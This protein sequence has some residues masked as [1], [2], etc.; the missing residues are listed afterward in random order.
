MLNQSGP[1]PTFREINFSELRPGLHLEVEWQERWYSVRVHQIDLTK[2]ARLVYIDT[3]EEEWLSHQDA[4]S[5]G[6]RVAVANTANV[7]NGPSDRSRERLEQEGSD[8]IDRALCA[9]FFL[10]MDK[11]S[12][13][14]EVSVIPDLESALEKCL[15]ALVSDGMPLFSF[16]MSAKHHESALSLNQFIECVKAPF[17]GFTL[18]DS[19]WYDGASAASEL[20]A[21]LLSSGRTGTAGSQVQRAESQ[22]LLQARPM[23][24]CGE[25]AGC[26]GHALIVEGETT[27][28]THPILGTLSC[29]TCYDRV[30]RDFEVDVRQTACKHCHRVKI[31]HCCLWA[32]SSMRCRCWT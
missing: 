10:Y 23:T 3:G 4:L 16:G 11:E 1:T 27:P 12:K 28:F 5:I 20:A 15:N 17:A 24:D 19:K 13:T 6:I 7:A 14:V 26:G 8:A 31:V 9:L 21:D 32:T 2:G 18:A 22:G 25:C 30:N 29:K